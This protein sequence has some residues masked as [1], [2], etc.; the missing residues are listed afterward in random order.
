MSMDSTRYDLTTW[1]YFDA[2]AE[3]VWAAISDAEGWPRWWRGIEE[4]VTLEAGGADGLGAR[5]RYVCLSVL[6]FY[7]TFTGCVTRIEPLRLLE[8]RVEGDVEGVGCCFL[9]PEGRRTAVRYEWRIRTNRLWM[10]RLGVFAQ[11][12]FRW[13]HEALMHAGG[14][15]LT[16][17]LAA[18]GARGAL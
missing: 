3:A 2:P 16:R 14:E 7:L 13:N 11:P 4:V 9:E 17:H 12:L 10:N 8:G 5:R 18:G 6:P 1:W 15:G